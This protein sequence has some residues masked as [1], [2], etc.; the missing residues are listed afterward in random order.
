M[1]TKYLYGT[2]IYD[3]DEIGHTKEAVV[4]KY[5]ECLPHQNVAFRFSGI[6]IETIDEG[7]HIKI[8]EQDAE[9]NWIHKV[10]FD[11]L[12]FKTLDDFVDLVLNYSEEKV[13]DE[14]EKDEVQSLKHMVDLLSTDEKDELLLH[15]LKGKLK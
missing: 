11:A 4:N 13:K 6:T 1:L 15:F 8:C 12:K 3:L 7:N 10:K 14:Y 5:S 9:K 2:R